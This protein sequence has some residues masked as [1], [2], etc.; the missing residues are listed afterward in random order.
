MGRNES[1]CFSTKS[2]HEVQGSLWGVLCRLENFRSIL[3]DGEAIFGCFRSF[4]WDFKAILGD[5]RPNLGSWRGS[6]A[7]FR[8]GKEGWCLFWGLLCLSKGV[9][10]LSQGL[11]G[12]FRGLKAYSAAFWSIL[13]G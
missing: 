10:D 6:V 1:V 2:A 7:C 11:L 3:R 4:M 5:K 12:Q 13:E 9:G 8:P